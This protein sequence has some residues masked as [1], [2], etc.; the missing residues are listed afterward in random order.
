MSDSTHPL[1]PAAVPLLQGDG[2]ALRV[3]GVDT[4]DG[5]LVGAGDL[6]MAGLLRGLDGRRSQRA[7]LADALRDGLA[8]ALVSGVLDALRSAGLLVD[9]DPAD[10]LAA[11]AGPAA[12]ARTA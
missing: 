6:G 7:V 3:G 9:L 5:V 2:R 10:L 12:A 11:D 4:V 1:L 8:P